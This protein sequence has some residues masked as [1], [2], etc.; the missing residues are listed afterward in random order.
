M[1]FIRRHFNNKYFKQKGPSAFK[2]AY[3]AIAKSKTYTEYCEKVHGVDIKM[4]NTLSNDQLLLLEKKLESYN[5]NTMLDLGSGN[6]ELTKYIA[7]KYSIKTTGIDFSYSVSD[8]KGC[9]FKKFDTEDFKLDSKFDL[10]L[11][12]DSFYMIKDYKSFLKN[13]IE[14]LSPNGKIL[15]FFTIV[16]ETL[17][18]HQI[19]KACNKLSLKMDITNLTESD[20][21]FW[22]LSAGVLEDLNQSFVDE[23]QFY[24]WGIKKKEAD[25]NIALHR[26]G[27]TKR[28]LLELSTLS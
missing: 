8:V 24:L 17:E 9:A 15:I 20:S 25:K 21:N 5:V 13:L 22:E 19:T 27:S 2:K 6:G 16:D 28:Y 23:D 26:S 1:N 3:E 12:V 11:S 7:N 10:I 18:R 4:L 14:H